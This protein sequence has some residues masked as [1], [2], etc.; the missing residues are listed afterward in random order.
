MFVSECILYI[1]LIVCDCYLLNIQMEN[2][3][4]KYTSSLKQDIDVRTYKF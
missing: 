4:K 1:I 2:T 3:C